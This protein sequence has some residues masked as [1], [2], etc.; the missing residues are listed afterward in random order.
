MLEPSELTQHIAQRLEQSSRFMESVTRDLSEAELRTQYDPEFSPIGWHLGHVAWQEECWILRGFAGHDPIDSDLDPV[1]DS[2]QPN[3]ATRG[4]A[5]PSPSSLSNYRKQVRETVLELLPRLCRAPSRTLMEG[6]GLARFVA[7]HENQHTETVLSIRL[8]AGLFL[9]N[10]R[11]EEQPAGAPRVDTSYITIPAARI[12][13]GSDDDEDG[14]DNERAEHEVFVRA[15]A[16]RRTPV[17]NGE[18]LT[19]VEAGG[20]DD[21]ALWSA[22]GREWKRRVG[23]RYPLYWQREPSGGWLERSLAGV[24]PLVESQPVCHVCWHEAR[25]FARHAEARLP[26]EDEWERVASHSGGEKR[27]Y[28]WGNQPLPLCD[29]ALTKRT[30]APVGSFLEGASETGILHLTGGVWEWTAD[31]F[32]PYSGF[33]PQAYAGYSQPWFDGRHRVARGGSYVTAPALARSTFRNWYL[34]EMRR[35]F[36]GVRLARDA[37]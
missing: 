35:P 23:A 25:A 13:M 30:R 6:A 26:T 18:W 28:A 3:K 36:L 7:N 14:W 2:F 17:T 16:M 11:A 27:R 1:F 37:A 12:R 15:F 32:A 21:D 9:P 29:W 34:P 5:I 31:C 33:E 19:F 4:R 10:D 22:E 20:Y 8:S 24:F